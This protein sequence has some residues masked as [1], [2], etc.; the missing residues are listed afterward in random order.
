MA[1]DRLVAP[2]PVVEPGSGVRAA[3]RCQAMQ[4]ADGALQSQ[5]RRVHGTEARIAAA[6]RHD[7]GHRHGLG[8]GLVG[9]RE[10]HRVGG[11]Q[12]HQ[13][14]AAIGEPCCE[15]EPELGRHLEAGP[16]AVAGAGAHGAQEVEQVTA[17]GHPSIRATC[18]N[19]RTSGAGR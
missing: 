10:H 19:Q 12:A 15:I 5:G 7:A 3:V 13:V 18:S 2:L 1:S 16:G 8:L 11:E 14:E 4:I 9:H 6:M 17:V